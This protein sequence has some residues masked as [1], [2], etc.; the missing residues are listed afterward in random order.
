MSVIYNY[1][2][3]KQLF[4]TLKKQSKK[5]YYAKQYQKQY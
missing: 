4:E 1:K 2:T 5:V 3:Y